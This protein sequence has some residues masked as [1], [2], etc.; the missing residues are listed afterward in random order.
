[1]E[2]GGGEEPEAG[3]GEEEEDNAGGVI[4]GACAA[5]DSAAASHG[6]D[7]FALSALRAEWTWGLRFSCVLRTWGN[8]EG[9]FWPRA[10]E[11]AGPVRAC[12]GRPFFW[13]AAGK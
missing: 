4:A 1:M 6:G 3:G 5:G 10:G 11:V 9:R 12:L 8:F 7:P 2:E 13:A